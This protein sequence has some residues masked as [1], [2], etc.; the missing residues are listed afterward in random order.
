[1]RRTYTFPSTTNPLNP[2]HLP[3]DFAHVANLISLSPPPLSTQPYFVL[4][5][6]WLRLLGVLIRREV[7]GFMVRPQCMGDCCQWGSQLVGDR[8]RDHTSNFS[9]GGEWAVLDRSL[10]AF[11]TAVG[12]EPVP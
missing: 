7:T 12:T 3:F 1:M 2:S 4:D 8:S 10:T 6:T 5:P 11:R 9:R